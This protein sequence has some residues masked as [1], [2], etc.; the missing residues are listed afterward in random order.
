MTVPQPATQGGIATVNE[1]LA[2]SVG[3]SRLCHGTFIPRGPVK[4]NWRAVRRFLDARTERA[5]G[6]AKAK[7]PEWTGVAC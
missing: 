7:R 1:L 2:R 5:A 6:R 4:R 3:L